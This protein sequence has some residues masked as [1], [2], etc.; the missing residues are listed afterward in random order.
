MNKVIV[1]KRDTMEWTIKQNEK[2]KKWYFSVSGVENKK[3]CV[4]PRYEEIVAQAQKSGLSVEN[5]I[6]ARQFERYFEKVTEGKTMPLP[7]EIELDPSF[8]TRLI[9]DADKTKAALYIRKAKEEPHHIDK[10]LITAMLNNSQIV[11]IDFAALDEKINAFIEST[12]RETEFVI[13]EGTL[14][15]RGKD[16]TLIPHI[17]KLDESEDMMLRKKL[18]HAVG[19]AR[20]QPQMIYDKDFPLSEAQSLCVVAKHDLLFEFS[21]T[22]L[23]TSGADIYGNAIQGL[24]GND[25]FVL[26]LRNITQTNDEL[27]AGCSGILLS[28]ESPDGLKLRIIPYKEATVTAVISDDKMEASLILESGR[29]A[30]ARLSISRLKKALDEVGLPADR[31]TEKVLKDAIYEA[32]LS[33]A[34][35]E[36]TVS[37]GIP[38]VAPHSYQFDWKVD[39]GHSNA[40]RNNS[41]NILSGNRRKRIRRVRYYHRNRSGNTVKAA[42][43]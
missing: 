24:P 12:D 31:Y 2:N 34:P 39:F 9:I 36:F 15:G 7:L 37:R 29:G 6:N 28:A 1:Y 14:P 10:K 27:T 13:A 21:K 25:P 16:R 42:P 3:S 5:M 8:D 11:Q 17:T 30:G 4:F 40:G 22:E 38:P 19:A 20:E 35:I 18:L 26:D 41:G 43:N 23:G 32:R 33:S